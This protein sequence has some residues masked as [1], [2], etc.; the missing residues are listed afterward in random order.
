MH[1]NNKSYRPDI[2]GLR[3]IAVFSV[4]LFHLHHNNLPGGFTGVDVFFVISGFLITNILHKEM[5]VGNFSILHFY[6]RRARRILPALCVVT[7]IVFA[8]CF[9]LFFPPD[10]KDFGQSTSATS[11]FMSN[12]LFWKE[13]GYFALPS[14]Q[15]PL[16]HTWSLAIEEQ[17]YIL[18]P[19]L[20]WIL[21]KFFTHTV[22]ILIFVFFCVASFILSEY[23]VRF[24]PDAAF[25]LI[26]SRAWELGIGGLI[27]LLQPQI[28]AFLN[29]TPRTVLE[30]IPVLGALM[31]IYSLFAFNE[32]TAFPGISALFPTIGTALIIIAGLEHGTYKPL[33]N[34]LIS[35]KW[36]VIFG[37]IS[38]SL[39]LIHWPL[40]T[41]YKY[42]TL[43]ELNFTAQLSVGSISILL[44]YLSWRFIEQPIRAISI[45][46]K[47]IL[48]TAGVSL[49]IMF[50]LG[51]TIHLFNGFPERF[52]VQTNTY[53]KAQYSNNPLKETCNVPGFSKHVTLPDEEACTFGDLSSGNLY[54]VIVWGDSH[55]DHIV[56]AISH[57]LQESTGIT[58]R[59]I[60][61]GGCPPLIDVTRQKTRASPPMFG[62]TETNSKVLE[63]IKQNG[64]INTVVLSARWTD[65]INN[66]YLKSSTY[67][68]LTKEHTIKNL[69]LGLERTLE[70]LKKHNKKVILLGPI[71]EADY[72]VPACLA[73]KSSSIFSNFSCL[74]REEENFLTRNKIILEALSQ[75]EKSFTNLIV[76]QPYKSLCSEGKCI[77]QDNLQ[78]L[79]R[80]DDHLSIYGAKFLTK[81]IKPYLIPE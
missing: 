24:Y 74:T 4:L 1:T 42:Y 22:S 25:Y 56:P 60:T 77:I 16:L 70:E 2:D 64:N 57:I 68:T 58:A 79:Y 6:E 19:I 11:L 12:I 46:Q 67:S 53:I 50:V 28:I 81:D 10:F 29:K 34:Q 44:A 18:F 45:S 14:L 80:N 75:L 32:Y 13:S 52:S 8:V 35:Y 36:F 31:I 38:Y 55:A 71:P 61:K 3:A 43:K 9:F 76:Y 7:L 66:S 23:L 65:Y 78:S 27:A 69:L 63:L 54:S 40:I 37:L 30:T 17:F 49:A 39:Y 47:F 73:R 62:C 48:V 15:K 5:R 33:L 26:P 59:Q 41:F 20:L 72:N 51:V 21:V